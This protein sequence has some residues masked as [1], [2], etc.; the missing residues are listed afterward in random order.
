MTT[1]QECTLRK[2]NP[3]LCWAMHGEGL[4]LEQMVLGWGAG[5]PEEGSSDGDDGG[6]P[7][8]GTTLGGDDLALT[9]ANTH[10]A[11]ELGIVRSEVRRLRSK[12]GALEREKDDMVDNF[13]TT[14]KIL[15]ERIK[16][17][18]AELS[19]SQSRPQTAAV[20][21]RIEH[22]RSR[23]PLP[24]A[25]RS[26]ATAAATTPNG[27][28]SQPV[29]ILRIEEGPPSQGGVDMEGDPAQDVV[30]M[31]GNCGKEIP[32]GNFISH[33]VFCY[34]NNYRCGTCDQVISCRDKEEHLRFWTDPARLLQ[35][36]KEQDLESMQ[37]M[38][39]HGM[40]FQSAVHPESGDRALHE[41]A[42]QDS[43]DLIEF[44]MGYGVDV[45]PI[46]ARGETPLH[47]A[48]SSA[49]VSTVRL[50][51]ELGADLNAANGQGEP[52]LILA[53]RRGAAMVA[54]FLVQMRADADVCTKLGDTAIQ[55]AQ[56]LGH[57][58]TVHALA[59]AGAPLR[60][61]TPSRLRENSPSPLQFSKSP[62]TGAIHHVSA[63][64][65]PDARG[66]PPRPRHR[67]ADRS[68]SHGRLR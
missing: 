62:S 37:A 2:A 8:L 53:C 25:R 14:T 59:T 9:L 67:L 33:T 6:R 26:S 17:L 29:E 68:P 35:A 42:R 58:D 10:T 60:P 4:H 52:P 54:S 28:P 66:Y 65:Y 48:A 34:K 21:Q 50:L 19:E 41:A 18:E 20:I 46:N 38:A 64:G 13:R 12:I 45:D 3:Y 55:I 43:A 49:G 30:Q 63:A 36:A 15:L 27:T 51:V 7:I 47:I 40:D 23:P 5:E 11:N 22:K 61:G 32:G 1:G 44:F 31:C 57:I 39:G 16:E 56:R 24:Q